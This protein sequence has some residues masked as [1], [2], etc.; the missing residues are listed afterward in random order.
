MGKQNKINNNKK[1]LKYLF[2]LEDEVPTDDELD[3]MAMPT[4][5]EIDELRKK[6]FGT[7]DNETHE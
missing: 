6:I 4:K 5:E 2:S 3:K 1:L 7:Y